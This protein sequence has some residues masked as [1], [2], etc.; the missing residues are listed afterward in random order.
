MPQ[1]ISLSP[2]ERGQAC[3]WYASRPLTESGR[4]P[5]THTHTHFTKVGIL[6]YI[7][8]WCMLLITP[9][10]HWTNIIKLSWFFPNSLLENCVCNIWRQLLTLYV[11][12]LNM[13]QLQLQWQHFLIEPLEG[14]GRASSCIFF[15]NHRLRLSLVL[16][17]TVNL[18]RLKLK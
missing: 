13:Y 12:M 7:C 8:M 16:S 18:R 2:P 10:P 1:W 4:P 6:Y 3:C 11:I 9:Q 5:P 14:R 15:S 17:S